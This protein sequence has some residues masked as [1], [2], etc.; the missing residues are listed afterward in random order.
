M[1]RLLVVL[2]VGIA[3][4][5]S[6]CGGNS[7]RHAVSAYINHVNEIQAKLAVPLADVT[8]ANR[9]FASAKKDPALDAQLA[10][11]ERTMQTLRRDL[12]AVKVPPEAKHLHALL[13]ELVDRQ[14]A[15]TQEVMQ[16]A[17]FVPSFQA[18]LK[19][20]TA[21]ETS[22][23]SELARTAKG[24]AATKALNA[25]K[26]IALETY[27]GTVGRVIASLQGL[28][29]P[30]VWKPGY[31]AQVGS[32]AEL[33]SSA[34]ALAAAVRAKRAAAIPKLLQRFDAAA[35]L[36]QSTAVQ[37]QQIAAVKAYNN[38]I[39]AVL[40]LGRKIQLEQGRLQRAYGS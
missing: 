4:F 27:A 38:R 17:T 8:S 22:L 39:K 28:V 21:A 11:A 16:L 14:V 20:L 5:A 15:L 18:A 2:A 30:P 7:K 35:V 40:V 24:A 3:F 23:K 34:L 32:L 29:A 25:E 19:P 12:A 1:R 10:Q 31:D 33:R 36:G 37:K 9:S 6:G 26:S 13:L